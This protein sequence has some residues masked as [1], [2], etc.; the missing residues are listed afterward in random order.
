MSSLAEAASG[1]GSAWDRI[2]SSGMVGGYLNVAIGETELPSTMVSQH[3]APF[4]FAFTDIVCS[5]GSIGPKGINPMVFNSDHPEV[6]LAGRVDLCRG[7]TGDEWSAA[8]HA[9][10]PQSPE[11][12]RIRSW[13]E[14]RSGRR[15]S[16]R[17]IGRLS[18]TES[19]LRSTGCQRRGW[20]GYRKSLNSRMD[21]IRMVR[22]CLKAS[23]TMH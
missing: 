22:S 1:T 9:V 13:A 3:T 2:F 8:F 16:G 5:P 17:I 18:P 4:C 20:R 12:R 11:E 23:R 21:L 14:R 15:W 7:A 19:R 6:Q 10:R